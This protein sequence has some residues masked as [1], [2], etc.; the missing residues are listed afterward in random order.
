MKNQNRKG[1]AGHFVAW[2]LA[3][4]IAGCSSWSFQPPMRGNP[5]FAPYNLGKLR[6]A[7]P[8][9]P[10]SFT[11]GLT[12]DYA[13]FASSLQDEL[14]DWADA[15]YFARKGLAAASGEAVPPEENSNWLIPLEVPDKFRSELAQA[16]ARLVAALDA[17]GRERMPLFAARAQVSY[18]CWVERM[19][20]DWKEAVNGP[21]RKQFYD[22]LARL[23]GRAQAAPP[24]QPATGPH[25]G[26]EYRVYFEFDKS[27][28]LPEAKEI[29]QQVAEVAKQRPAIRIL[30]VGKADRAGTDRYNMGLSERRADRVARALVDDGVPADRISTRWV[31]ER[32]PPVPTAAGVREPRNRVV[33]IT[34]Q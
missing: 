31:G 29:L 34:L 26:G 14:H 15:D 18:D 9:S 2:G 33:E 32:E 21:C 24:A 16:R 30:L 23:Q 25:L 27:E 20:D 1:I 17:G 28:L 4:L 22:A 5:S 7:V 12:S 13:S 11:Q 6:A 19:E 10:A 8:A 3:L